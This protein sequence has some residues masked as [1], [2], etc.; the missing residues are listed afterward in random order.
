MNP[1]PGDVVT[2]LRPDRPEHRTG[3]V[4]DPHG[5]SWPLWVRHQ[6]DCWQTGTMQGH[7]R[8]YSLDEVT[9]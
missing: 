8:G 6:C 4:V 3:T 2:V 5:P 9:T 7:E 1:H